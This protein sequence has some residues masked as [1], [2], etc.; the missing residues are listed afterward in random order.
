MKKYLITGLLIW[1]PL[2]ITF[3]VLAWIVGTL[4][5][6]IEWL[7]DGMQPRAV[8]GFNVPGVGLL[9]SVLIVLGT[10]LAL[11]FRAGALNIGAEG[12]FFIGALCS[13]YVGYSLTGLPGIIH[14]PLALLGGM[15]GGALWGTIPG[16]LKA[17]FGAH[18]VVNTIMMN[19]I[20]FRLSDIVDRQ[21]R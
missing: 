16:Y 3:M 1:I 4:D 20:A 8:F 18:E 15:A 21:A 6:I 9:V 13:A 14:L 5:Q 17:R 11:A 10:G 19:W 7:P 2:A 12:Q